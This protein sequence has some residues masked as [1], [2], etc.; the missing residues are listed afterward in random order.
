MT[1]DLK[2]ALN[3]ARDALDL[4][5]DLREKYCG[6][7]SAYC[8][9]CKGPCRDESESE[10]ES[11]WAEE[12]WGGKAT[13]TSASLDAKDAL[14]DLL[15]GIGVWKA[16]KFPGGWDDADEALVR[17]IEAGTKTE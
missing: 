3:I 5:D 17:W 13:E 8:P 6:E 10:N 15:A 16:A 11:D 14:D 2:L 7:D 1:D 12:A 4:L 9:A